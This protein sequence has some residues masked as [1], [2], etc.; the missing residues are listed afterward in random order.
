MKTPKRTRPIT[1]MIPVL[2]VNALVILELF[3]GPSRCR[4]M[5]RGSIK[6]RSHRFGIFSLTIVEAETQS[7][8]PLSRRIHSLFSR[9]LASDKGKGTF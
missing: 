9:P 8:C 1:V 3:R 4:K 7:I 6:G 2:V 5:R